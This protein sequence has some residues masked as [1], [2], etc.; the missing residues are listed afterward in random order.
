MAEPKAVELNPKHEKTLI[1]LAK[2]VVALK[3][4]LAWYTTERS[5]LLGKLKAA[6]S[7]VS[8][9]EKDVQ[10]AQSEVVELKKL[11]TQLQRD[12]EKSRKVIAAYSSSE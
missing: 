4:R 12:L 1:Q 2:Q 8:Q 9:S 6:K 11:T 5:G 3:E 7:A 10:K